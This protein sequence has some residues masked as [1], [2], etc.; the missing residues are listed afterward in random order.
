MSFGLHGAPATSQKMVDGILRGSEEFTAALLDDIIVFSETWEQHL[1]HVREVLERLRKA[2]LTAKPSKCR[3]GMEVVE[4]LWHIVGWGRVKL[5]LSK[6]QAMKD[7][8]RPESMTD[9]RAFLGLREYYRNFIPNYA[10]IA[11]RYPIWH[12][13]LHRILSSGTTNV[14]RLLQ[15]WRNDF[16]VYQC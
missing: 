9:V 16:V 8:P 14:E 6:I 1:Q 12:V 15:P 7:F 10:E 3:F 13:R 4:Y 5:A 11:A 2:G